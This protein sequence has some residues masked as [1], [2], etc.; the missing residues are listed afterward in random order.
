M[1][2][3]KKVK[4]L[5]KLIRFELPFSA[6]V[7]VVMGQILAI[8]EF[9][10]LYLIFT[11]F[12]TVFMISASILVLNDYFDI[13]I[14]RI[15]SPDRPLPSNLVTPSEAVL[16]SIFLMCGGL[17]LSVLISLPLFLLSLILIVIGFLY[18]R[19][20]KKSGLPG[21]LMVS[22]SVGMTFIFGGATVGFPFN[23]LVVLF[24]VIAALVDLGEEIAADSTDV[25]GDLLIQSNSLAIK[26]G[27]MTAVKISGS[28]FLVVILLTLIP[29]IT[30]WL[31]PVYLIP[32]G[33]MDSAIAYGAIMIL[34]KNG[35]ERKKNI[36]IIYLGATLGIILF[37]LMRLAGL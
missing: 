33:V 5:L 17:V 14:D 7:C 16:F 1:T 9:A 30:H 8:G 21:N 31:S 27:E 20:F 35:R 12:L 28:V 3:R 26:L 23:R 10:S 18:N 6:G 37:I 2:D 13:E 19:Y 25:E 34:R 29:F 32:L 4:G 11:G 24:A 22:L 15:N 36:R